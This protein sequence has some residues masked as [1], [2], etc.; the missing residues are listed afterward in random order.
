MQISA[1]WN[2]PLSQFHFRSRVAL[3]GALVLLAS[4]VGWQYYLDIQHQFLADKLRELCCSAEFQRDVSTAGTSL[5][6]R[7]KR[8]WTRWNSRRIR[9][10]TFRSPD[11]D[12][13]VKAIQI[14]KQIGSLDSISSYETR[15]SI[16]QVEDL[17][18]GVR[19]SALYIPS[20]PLPR[21]RLPFLRNQTLQWLCVARTQFSN[22]AIQDLPD[23][24][25][26]FDATRT[27]INDAG[28]SGFTRLKR[29]KTLILRRTPT[30]SAGIG[31]LQQQMPWC[32]I[33][34]EPL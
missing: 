4:F 13:L 15:I 12:K 7:L 17:L 21:T 14:V 31:R 1:L 2:R 5:P 34:W 27:R 9:D 33:S 11:P 20:E 32:R 30:T 10:V 16:H 3:A 26:Y 8:G 28:L 19:P 25:T 23:S 29:L 6:A 22:P 18:T 24:L